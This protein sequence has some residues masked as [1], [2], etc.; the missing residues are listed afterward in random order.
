MLDTQTLQGIATKLIPG[1]D[2]VFPINDLPTTH[3]KSYI[4]IVNTDPDNLIGKH[5]LGVIVRPDKE[6]YV[7]DSYGQSP[8]LKLQH[9]L[10]IRGIRWTSNTRQVQ[11]FNSTLCGYFC[12][13]FLWF[14][15]TNQMHDEHF[16]N[17]MNIL[18]PPLSLYTYY[19]SIV[20]D[21]VKVMNI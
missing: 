1:F 9:W 11:S 7:F 13:Y 8:P 20:N 21:F 19:D 2:G 12:I 6:G 10:N 16:V 4:L 17:I 18:F 3:K 15:N 14:A 5:W